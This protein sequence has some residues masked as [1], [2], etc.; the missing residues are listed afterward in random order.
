M[1][2]IV[3]GSTGFI[4]HALCKKI[5][6]RGHKLIMVIRPGTAR[7]K[8]LEEFK[9]KADIV[10]LEL[11]ELENLYIKYSITADVFYHLAWNGSSGG[12]RENFDIQYSN[13]GYMASAIRAAKACNCKRIIGAG[14]Q[15]EYGV[16]K[17][18]AYEYK[19]AP[20]PFMMYGAAKTSAYYMG[21]L[22]ASQLNI[23]FVWPRIYSVYGIGEN[24]GTLVSYILRCVADG[25]RPE[26]S[27][28]ENLWNFINI[29]DCINML[30]ALSDLERNISG[31][32][33][34]ASEDTRVLRDFVNEIMSVTNAE[35]Q[36]V[37]G[38][39]QNNPDRT[40]WLDPDISRME[41]LG[42]ECKVTFAEG[43][44]ARYNE[45]NG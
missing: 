26:L 19:T 13:I 36:P 39:R 14:S 27:V 4:G 15:A 44:A 11:C 21:R 30:L 17:N 6:E 32:Y 43:I 25:V 10:E 18:R 1:K 16:V 24:D 9:G 31:V 8:Q 5:I 22:L 3:T 23:E 33:H 42:I 28:C 40:F 38:A 12:D 45:M 2:Y 35:V 41:A 20:N 29:D 34:I 37:F 7:K